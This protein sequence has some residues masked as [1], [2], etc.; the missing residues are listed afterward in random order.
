MK[1]RKLLVFWVN[2]FVLVGLYVITVFYGGESIGQ[3]GQIIIIM[4]VGN[5][6][7]YTGGQVA[8]AWQRSK[9]FKREL[10]GR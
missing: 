10:D 2:L 5:G 4:L 3:V 1:S 6:A 8:D 9:Y 7:V